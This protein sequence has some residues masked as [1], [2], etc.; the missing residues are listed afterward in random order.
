ME[1]KSP[2][3]DLGPIKK[4]FSTASALRI[5]RTA[6]STA[7]AVGL[8]LEDIVRLIQGIVRPHFYKSMTSHA[9]HRIW[10][11]VYHVPWGD[12][13]L[14]VKFTVDAEGYLVISFKEK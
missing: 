10:Q 4:V 14:H 6:L 8:T 1:K 13:A 7:E 11:D 3:Y 2:H 5:T 9:D 12:I